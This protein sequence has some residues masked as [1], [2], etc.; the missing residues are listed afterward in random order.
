MSNISRYNNHVQAVDRALA[1]LKLIA[2]QS[3]PVPLSHLCEAT[4]LN[5]TTVWRLLCTLE[6]NGFVEKNAAAPDYELGIA[7]LN[8]SSAATER[9][10]PLIRRSHPV[11]QELTDFC[12]ESVLLSVSRFSGICAIDQIDPPQSI[13]L[14]NY[15]NITTP[16]HCSSTGK[17][18][19]SLLP[20][21]ELNAYLRGHLEAVTEY[22]ITDPSILRRQLEQA[23]VSGYATVEGEL[24]SDENGISAPIMYRSHMIALLSIGGPS[25]R[26]TADRMRELAPSLLDA[27]RQISRLLS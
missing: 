1:L 4:G 16:L 26:L 13:C 25:Y 7:A 15:I 8:L 22:T 20:S 11:M 18:L 5:R 19:L 10:A 3:E 9:Y 2:E 21:E 27:S 17:V 23:A 6:D 14:K 12:Q 24:S